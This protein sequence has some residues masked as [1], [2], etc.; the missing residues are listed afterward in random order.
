MFLETL[1]RNIIY[2]NTHFAIEHTGR[3]EEASIGVIRVKEKKG[4]LEI[5][6]SK[7]V[8]S[9][10]KVKLIFSSIRSA[11]LVINNDQVLQKRVEHISELSDVALLSKAFSSIDLNVF[12]YEVVR[13]IKS[14]LIFI[15]RK[16]YI[17]KLILLYRDEKIFIT[18]WSLGFAP[19]DRV[20]TLL[21]EN[22]TI[23]TPTSIISY[24]QGHLDDLDP[25][26]NLD[27][28]PTNYC[29]EDLEIS[30]EQINALG[31][32][33][34][35]VGG[36][37]LRCSTN[38][39]D[40][41]K[42]YLSYFKQQRLFDLGL[43]T[44]IVILLLVFL[45]NFLFYNYYYQEVSVLNEIGDTNVIQKQLLI[46]KDSLVDQKQ[47]LFEDVI[48]SSSSS[49]SY[50]I[51]QIVKKMPETISLENLYYA[52]LLKKIRSGKPVDLD[53]S[54]ILIKGFTAENTDISSWIS[55]I[56]EMDFI[57]SVSIKNL[58]KKS[59]NTVFTIELQ[60]K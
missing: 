33:I 29:I 42:A 1:S 17:D 45:I 47:K 46:K 3:D 7:K 11:H 36:N 21:N 16:E 43:P 59:S 41:E 2:G 14:S 37:T 6:D 26:Q 18:R 52:P 50:Y 51:D 9:L 13:G 12:Y 48:E 53:S 35:T 55:D 31:A 23:Q 10:K 5:T 20:V 38:Y 28:S 25:T 60:K 34:T 49:S 32:V 24:T 19:L 27:Y 22:G 40:R 39:E 57:Q 15:C 8:S 54:V 56:E 30:D 58:D 44:G 4:E